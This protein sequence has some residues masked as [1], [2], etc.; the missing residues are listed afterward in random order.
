[1]LYQMSH[2]SREP[3]ALAYD[4]RLD[5]LAMAVQYLSPNLA[6]RDL[7]IKEIEERPY[8]SAYLM[9]CMLLM[10]NKGRVSE[11]NLKKAKENPWAVIEAAKEADRQE[12]S[13]MELHARLQELNYN[14]DPST[15]QPTGRH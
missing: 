10:G 14:L 8:H 1:M 2:M 15:N 11:A 9:A 4:D 3:G 12:Q 13:Q 6:Q 7:Q 5:A